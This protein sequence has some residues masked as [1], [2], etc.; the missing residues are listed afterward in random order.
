MIRG[1]LPMIEDSIAT[2]SDPVDQALLSAFYMCYTHNPQQ[3]PMAKE[4]A[5]YLEERWTEL[6]QRE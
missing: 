5:T 6:S 1:E 3:R 2:S 4:V